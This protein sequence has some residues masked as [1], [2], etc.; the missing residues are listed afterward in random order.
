MKNVIRNII[1]FIITWEARLVLRKYKP[2]IIAVTGSVGKTSTKDAIYEVLQNSYFTRKSERSF[3]SEFGVPLT[4]IGCDTGWRNPFSWTKNIIEGLILILFPNHYPAWL[5][6]EVGTDKPGD[7]KTIS[8]W[9][10]S[11]IVV[12]TSLPDIPVHVEHFPNLKDIIDEKKSLALALKEEGTLIINGDDNL[13]KK[14]SKELSHKSFVISYG[15]ENHNDIV[16]SHVEITYGNNGEP[17][18]MNFRVNEKGSSVPTKI[19]GRIGQQQV[20]PVLAA[21]AVAKAMGIPPLHTAGEVAKAC[22]SPGR[23]RV[24]KGVAECTII[25]DSY[26]SSPVALRAALTLLKKITAKGKKIAILG[27]MLELGHFST[28]AHRRAGAQVATAADIL[29]T[30]GIRAKEIAKQARAKG[31]SKKAIFE[32]DS[33]QSQDAGLKARELIETG[34]IVLVKGS[35]TGIRLEKAVRVLLKDSSMAHELLVRQELVW[36]RQ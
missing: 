21:F 35:Q 36:L 16:A 10:R 28:E 32:F 6:L 5:I 31:F 8:K 26:N 33:G 18:G 30:V 29:I 4:I 20:Y 12:I 23:M 7:I 2:M 24:L 34:D 11:D 15:M 14:L 3:N 1:I 25:D 17:Q 22:G 19:I 9:L 27:D 13:S